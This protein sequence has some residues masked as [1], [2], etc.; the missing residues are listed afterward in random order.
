[1]PRTTADSPE[2]KRLGRYQL[3]RKIAVGGMAELYLARVTGAAGFE[4]DVVIKRILPQLAESDE[5]YQMFLDEA[6]IA[7]T[8]Q[9]PNVVQ[10]YDAQ[11]VGGEHFIAMEYLDGADLL[12]L[13]RILAERRQGLPIQHSVYIASAVAAGLHYAHE[14]VG[15]DGKP[16][17][18]VH[19]DVTPQNILIT[20][21][22]GIKLVDFGIA[23][24][25][26][27][28]SS[29]GYGTLKGKLAYMSPEQCRSE[30]VDR[31]SD[32][33]SLGIVLFELT[34]GRRL[35]RGLSEYEILRQVV[36]GEV[37]APSTVLPG[38]PPD[39]EQILLRALARDR[40]AR[41]QTALEL[42]R[43]LEGF[44]RSRGVVGSALALA[45]FVAP[46]L[47]EAERQAE[48]R[49]RRRLSEA[50][51]EEGEEGGEDAGAPEGD[52]PQR[53]AAAAPARRSAP[54]LDSEPVLADVAPD[55]GDIR[56]RR[57]GLLPA[58][59][60]LLLI[61]GGAATF[62]YLK[63]LRPAA[64]AGLAAADAGS[65]AAPRPTEA[66]IQVDS[67]PPG[68]AVW[69]RLGRTPAESGPLDPR[70]AHRVRVEHD[71]YLP[72]DLTAEPD[73]FAPAGAGGERRAELRFE[74]EPASGGEAPPD[75]PTAMPGGAG[76]PPPRGG[77]GVLRVSSE[78]P[79]ATAWLLVGV[80]PARI[81]P[82]P[83]DG[84]IQLRVA[85]D[86]HLPVYRTIGPDELGP[87]GETSVQVQLSARATPR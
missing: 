30:P 10:I 38:Y 71:G 83:A 67:A 18:I 28:M 5:F 50:G 23:K 51:E 84:P 69:L 73:A 57:S 27:R 9:H 16:L 6:R 20:R 64:E 40:E 3:L 60:A 78:P 42:Q 86:D 44:A 49:L 58:L 65:D 36:E 31:R 39:L 87:G 24:A 53:G 46:L 59:I 79:A 4:K 22:G 43:D 85:L 70:R 77:A 14:K 80:T 25:T 12:T 66:W 74:L 62:Y 47:E 35:Y 75:E 56:L 2:P 72:R 33:Y 48:E 34:T 15:L 37:P 19:R 26:N 7:A 55:L 82:L 32:I 81:G 11:Q 61:G 17:A 13:R 21:D 1:M 54:R 41:Y 63:V 8:L 45:E 29:T 68:A 76:E 52:R